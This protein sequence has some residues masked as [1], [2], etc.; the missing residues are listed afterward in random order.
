L[1]LA[2]PEEELRFF[3]G[4]RFVVGILY[5]F[6]ISDFGFWIEAVTTLQIALTLSGQSGLGTISPKFVVILAEEPK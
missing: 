5:L 2:P 3:D 1:A 4:G 6:W